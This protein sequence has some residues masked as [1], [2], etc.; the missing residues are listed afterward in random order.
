MSLVG[1]GTIKMLGPVGEDNI[2]GVP[3]TGAVLINID[4]TIQGTGTIGGGDGNLT[5]ENFGIVNANDD[6]LTINTGNQ[7]YNDGVMEAT[8]DPLAATIGTLWI[9]DSVVNAGTVQADGG[10]AIVELFGATFG[11]LFSV[12]AKNL[13]S[14]SFFNVAVTNEAISATNPFGGTISAAGGFITFYGGSIANNNVMEATDGGLLR[15]ENIIVTNSSAAELTI[16]ATAVLSLEG[17]AVLGGTIENAGN[18]T[19]SGLSQLNGDTVTNSGAIT[20]FT[21]GNL[22]LEGT[23]LT[24]AAG[25]TISADDGG[26][27]DI[28]INNANTTNDGTISPPAARSPSMSMPMAAGMT[29]PSKPTAASSLSTATAAEAAVVAASMPVEITA[30]S[31]HSTSAPSA[32][33]AA[34]PTTPV[35]RSMPRRPVRSISPTARLT[36]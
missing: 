29:A 15:L 36:I 4:Y 6:V 20:V 26:S 9:Q 19:V 33:M 5:F 24:N 28:E 7:V 16:G 32:S 34:S 25:A 17:A 30:R 1:G 23:T 27:V 21:G 35:R 2:L 11:N 18:V 31:Q 22:T 14:I 8:V 10:L 12:V 3:G 13:G